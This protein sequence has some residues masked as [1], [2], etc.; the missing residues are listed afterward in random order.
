MILSSSPSNSLVMLCLNSF[1][2]SPERKVVR[3]AKICILENCEAQSDIRPEDSE[4]SLW[5]FVFKVNAEIIN[6]HLHAKQQL[7]GIT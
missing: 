1:S 7:G 2:A 4:Y 5:I 6:V 3:G